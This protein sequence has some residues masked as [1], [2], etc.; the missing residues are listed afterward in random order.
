MP[1]GG[2]W[3]LS[4]PSA[5]S[6]WRPTCGLCWSSF[7][8]DELKLD[9]ELFSAHQGISGRVSMEN[10]QKAVKTLISTLGIFRG[11][12]GPQAMGHSPPILS[13]SSQGAGTRQQCVWGLASTRLFCGEVKRS[14][15]MPAPG[16]CPSAPACGPSCPERRHL[17]VLGWKQVLQRERLP[18]IPLC[19]FLHSITHSFG[20]HS[21]CPLL[22]LS[23]SP[24]I[25]RVAS[26]PSTS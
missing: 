6:A 21:E 4:P 15:L 5:V 24:N 7:L 2:P 19:S 22:C 25:I 26:A 3:R 13:F 20:K 1:S 14:L 9:S 18:E 23:W 17:Q 11:F 10:N 8:A 16:R 12:P